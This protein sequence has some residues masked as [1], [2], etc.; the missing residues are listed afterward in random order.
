MGE[1]HDHEGARTN[2]HGEEPG[3]PPTHCDH[4]PPKVA[5]LRANG[6]VRVR[7]LGCGTVGPERASPGEAFRALLK[8]PYR[9]NRSDANSTCVLSDRNALGARGAFESRTAA[10]FR[11]LL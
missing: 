6:G 8:I 4:R 5:T 2:F 10:V 1:H 3:N 7:C 9:A 11:P